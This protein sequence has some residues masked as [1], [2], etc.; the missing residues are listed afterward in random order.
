M[1]SGASIRPE[2]LVFA[3]IRS[4]LHWISTP[5]RRVIQ[6]FAISAPREISAHRLARWSGL[7]NRHQLARALARDGLPSLANLRSWIRLVGWVLAWESDRSSLYRLAIAQNLNPAVCF[8]MIKRLTGSRWSE[9]RSRGVA[10]VLLQFRDRCV[11][12]TTGVRSVTLSRR[13]HGGR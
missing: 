6:V 3:L 8:R 7:G 12:R 4:D 2:Q 5:T 13:Q 10:W 1:T 9:V 11:I